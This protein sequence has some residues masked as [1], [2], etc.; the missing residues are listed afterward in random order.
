MLAGSTAEPLT[1]A[2][3]S[4]GQYNPQLAHRWA[5]FAK[6]L[7]VLWRI[8]PHPSDDEEGASGEARP[9]FNPQ[10]SL[11]ATD[12]AALRTGGPEHWLLDVFGL[13]YWRAALG[14]QL[15][16]VEVNC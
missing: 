7:L 14:W 12:E 11:V 8:Q 15:C 6:T 5:F 1:A 16:K 2:R 4:S 9:V 10:Y 3:Q 13:Q